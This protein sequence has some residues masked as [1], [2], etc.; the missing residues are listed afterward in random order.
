[1]AKLVVSVATILGYNRCHIPRHRIKENQES[2]YWRKRLVIDFPN[3]LLIPI[4][5][6]SESFA[7]R[8]KGRNRLV[9]GPDYI[10]DA[11]KLPNQAPRGYGESL[12]TC[13]AWRCPGGTQHLFC[14]QF[15]P[16]MVNS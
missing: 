4:Y 10:V 15:W 5:Y 11:L 1:M 9:P 12:Q 3:L 2:P 6:H 13:V 14:W 7:M 8:E 16:F